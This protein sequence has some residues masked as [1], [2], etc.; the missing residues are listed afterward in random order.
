MK[1]FHSTVEMFWWSGV[2]YTREKMVPLRIVHRKDVWGSKNGWIHVIAV[3]PLHPPPFWNLYLYEC[4]CTAKL[5]A[6]SSFRF[7]G[8]LHLADQP[9]GPKTLAEVS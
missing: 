6:L 7:L 2:L 5:Q 4:S 1:P 8:F 3:N 9:K